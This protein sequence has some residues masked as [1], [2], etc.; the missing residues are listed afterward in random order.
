M[1]LKEN[2]DFCQ[3]TQSTL[4]K[5]PKSAKYVTNMYVVHPL[6]LPFIAYIRDCNGNNA[7]WV[8]SSSQHKNSC[9]SVWHCLRLDHITMS[10]VQERLN[11]CNKHNRCNRYSRC[12]RHKRC[13]KLCK[14]SNNGIVWQHHLQLQ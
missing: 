3:K 10:Q 8:Q 7:M 5:L 11:K 4:H 6:L 2:V 12:N 14:H 1:H 9:K 13:N